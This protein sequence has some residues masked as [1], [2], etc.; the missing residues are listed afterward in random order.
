[1]TTGSQTGDLGGPFR[2][3]LYRIWAIL[4]D[5]EVK[6]GKPRRAAPQL[7]SPTGAPLK[8]VVAA[9]TRPSSS[10]LGRGAQAKEF[11]R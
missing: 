2:G 5:L 11:F 1:V 9:R 4:S 8:L 10:Y 3:H 7:P 6:L